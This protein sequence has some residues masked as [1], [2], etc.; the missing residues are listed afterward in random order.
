MRRCVYI[1]LHNPN[2]RVR[3]ARLRVP[4]RCGTK[5][6][7]PNTVADA[8]FFAAVALRAFLCYHGKNGRVRRAPL[9]AA[10]EPAPQA[11]RFAAPADSVRS[12][13]LKS[14]R[15]A[16]HFPFQ[17]VLLLY[18]AGGF[19]RNRRKRRLPRCNSHNSGN[20]LFYSPSS[21]RSAELTAVFS[22][23]PTVHQSIRHSELL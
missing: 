15:L 16:V 12:R 5:P 11:L 2:C 6:P 13:F 18:S 8:F 1:T 4:G 3:A 20:T 22:L 9:E 19:R 23:Y 10:P 14:P 7:Q 21:D 17:S